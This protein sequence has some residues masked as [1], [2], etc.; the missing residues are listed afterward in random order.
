[1]IMTKKIRAYLGCDLFI[2][3]QRQQSIYVEDAL[4][5][6]LGDKIEIYNPT[7]N[8]EV[9]DP[10][11][12]FASGLDILIADYNELK[13]SDILIALM[14]TQD[15]GLA[16]EMGIAFERGLPIFQLYTDIRLLGNQKDSKIE[17][18]QD[19]IFNNA[20]MYVNQLVTALSYMDRD[21]NVYEEPTIYQKSDD[22]IASIVNYVN[23]EVE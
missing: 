21:G 19:D 18:L 2:E 7:T 5:E 4:N 20:F 22:L 9:N 6:Q 15:L 23:S 3:G 13:E 10:D 11:G 12:E 14:D 8:M 16:S 1:M 17:G